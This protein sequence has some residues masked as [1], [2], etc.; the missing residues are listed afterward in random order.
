MKLLPT[1]Q[2]RRMLDPR[3]AERMARRG[4][5]AVK[6]RARRQDLIGQATYRTLSVVHEGLGSAAHGLGRLAEASQPPVRGTARQAPTRRP[7]TQQPTRRPARQQQPARDGAERQAARDGA[8]RQ[9]ASRSRT[10]RATASRRS[11]SA[12]A[13]AAE[14]KQPRSGS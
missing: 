11:Q 14:R 10:R 13:E 5:G 6:Q 9:A 8:G 4:L 2:I 7:A 12:P 3:R 1:D